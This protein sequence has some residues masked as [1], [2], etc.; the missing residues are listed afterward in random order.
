MSFLDRYCTTH[1]DDIGNED[2]NQRLAFD[3][4]QSV[5]TFWEQNGFSPNDFDITPAGLGEL[6]S[7]LIV[8]TG[9]KTNQAPNR[10]IEIKILPKFAQLIAAYQAQDIQ[11]KTP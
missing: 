3:R 7:R 6:P 9:S 11:G 2:Y 4:A 5:V 1:T 8:K 10:R